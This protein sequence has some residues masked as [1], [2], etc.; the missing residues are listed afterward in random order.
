MA[1][2]A[3][4]LMAGLV[5]ADGDAAE[6]LDV[7]LQLLRCLLLVDGEEG[8]CLVIDPSFVDGRCSDET[9]TL[10]EHLWATLINWTMR[11]DLPT[12][13]RLFACLSQLMRFCQRFLPPAQFT[14]LASLPWNHF[15]LAEA[16]ASGSDEAVQL[17]NAFVIQN[18]QSTLKSCGRFLLHRLTRKYS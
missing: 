17:A 8:T 15:V 2:L 12:R 9:R 7:I 5:G 13:D 1:R 18:S 4:K 6:A 14:W 3:R 10:L 11:S 16:I